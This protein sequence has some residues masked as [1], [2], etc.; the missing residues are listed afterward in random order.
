MLQESAT[1]KPIH[2]WLRKISVASVPGPTTS[3]LEQVVANLLRHFRLRGH[4]VQATP[5]NRTDVTLTTA[6]FGRPL[7]WREALIFTARRRFNLSHSPNLYTLLHVPREEFQRLL[8][9]FQAALVKEALD[10][11]DY[12]FPGLAP[13]AYRVLCEQG[14]RG[15]PILA[16]ERLVQAQSKSIR[17]ILVIGDDRPLAA[18]HFDLVGAHPRSEGEYL[19]SFYD[20]IVLRIVTTVNAREV[21]QHEVVEE[22]I[23]SALWRRLNTPP[24]MCVAGRQLGKRHFFTE[25]VRIADLVQVPAV[26][27]VV[28]SQYSEGCFATWDPVLG[29]L[30]ATVTGSARPVDK[31]NITEDDLAVIVGV[32]PDGRGALTRHVEGKRNDP[33]SSEAVELMDMDSQLPTTE[34]DPVGGISARVPVTRS[35]LHGHRGIAAYDPRRVEYVP[36]DPPCYHYLVSCATDAQARAIKAAFARSEALQH[37]DDPRQVAFTVLPGHG[38][39]IVE[40]WVAGAAPF[41]VMWEYMDAG[42][43]Q[44][45]NRI[46]QGPMGYIPGPDGRMVLQ[47]AQGKPASLSE[48]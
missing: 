5:D 17:V 37:P 33:P 23:P 30:I 16:L 13:Q 2:P 21:T 40:K 42:Y 15:G 48:K 1:V 18:Y 24:A 44:V 35:K 29:G 47:T 20:D 4:R 46:P 11:A 14:R 6:P 38:V 25:M 36:L 43:L 45:D 41:Q 39:V 12:A 10:P 19:A 32:R 22:A 9:H 34:L 7:G 31:G 3:L 28:A 27:D 26:A 8:D